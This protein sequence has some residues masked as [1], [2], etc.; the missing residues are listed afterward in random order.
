MPNDPIFHENGSWFHYDET[1]ATVH[2]PFSSRQY[3][4]N[5]VDVYVDYLNRGPLA[6]PGLDRRSP[7]RSSKAW[8]RP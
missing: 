6:I 2:G 3:A 7:Q 8:S 4:A 5:A 1:W